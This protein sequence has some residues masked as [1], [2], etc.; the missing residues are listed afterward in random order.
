MPCLSSPQG[1]CDSV[2]LG[3]GTELPPDHLWPTGVPGTTAGQ[4]PTH[5]GGH[6]RHPGWTG[7]RYGALWG[8][9]SKLL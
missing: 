6:R 9:S 7:R 2:P 1:L 5:G 3:P 4:L 8:L